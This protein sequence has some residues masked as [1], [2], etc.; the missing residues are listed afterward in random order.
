MI[1]N[2]GD[3]VLFLGDNIP[4]ERYV[5]IDGIR[6]TISSTHL[7]IG[8]EYFI[9]GV[10]SDGDRISYWITA[11]NDEPYGYWTVETG[12]FYKFGTLKE[13]RKQKLEKLNSI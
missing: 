7:T 1:Y 6:C 9:N 13:W 5:L 2:K 12:G 8:K 11:D 3:N 10:N 4:K